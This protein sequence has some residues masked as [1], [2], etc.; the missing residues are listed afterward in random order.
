MAL[1]AILA[2]I[3][4]PVFAQ[5]KNAA[6][7]SSHST[8]LSAEDS[9]LKSDEA[10]LHYASRQ[11]G[12]ERSVLRAAT[13]QVQV[14]SLEKAETK[15]KQ[16]IAD[17]GGYIDH[18][19]GTDLAGDNPV[20]RLTI[21]VPEKSFDPELSEFEALGRRT[22]KSIFA[23]DLTEQI[24]DAEAQVKQAEQDQYPPEQLA[25]LRSGRD[26]IAGQVTMSSI[27]LTLE[28]RPTMATAAAANASW[29]SD[30]WNSAVGSAM[31]AFRVIGTIFI[32]L[33]V[34]SPLWLVPGL[35]ALYV[36]RHWKRSQALA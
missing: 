19:E 18:E 15:I 31:G 36:R 23:T 6:K 21:R 29:G 3:L 5:A 13:L 30:A 2:A 32:W 7:S 10:P 24:L 20:M 17:H 12:A 14:E 26:Q 16:S 22:E 28:Q 1:V 4:F 8:W 34:Y 33:F 27:D 11:P 9:M 25:Q 35:I